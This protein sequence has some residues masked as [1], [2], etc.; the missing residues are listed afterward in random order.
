[1]NVFRSALLMD[2]SSKVRESAIQG[3]FDMFLVFGPNNKEF[4]E[5]QEEVTLSHQF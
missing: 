4:I 3:L 2:P 1:M 5:Q